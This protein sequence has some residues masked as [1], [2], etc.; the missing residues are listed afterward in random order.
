[1]PQAGD[2]KRRK[3]ENENIVRPAMA[4]PIRQSGVRKVSDP[5]PTLLAFD[6]LIL[7]F[8]PLHLITINTIYRVKLGRQLLRLRLMQDREVLVKVKRKSSLKAKAKCRDRQIQW[9]WQNIPTP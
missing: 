2:Y 7:F 1:M 3:T 4:P 6:L 8:R 5:L 9:K